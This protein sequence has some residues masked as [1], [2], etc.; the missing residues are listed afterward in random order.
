M[1]CIRLWIA[2]Y[3]FMKMH[4]LIRRG[5]SVTLKGNDEQEEEEEE[6]EAFCLVF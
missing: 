5:V 3:Y 1:E 6:E 2:S 4:L